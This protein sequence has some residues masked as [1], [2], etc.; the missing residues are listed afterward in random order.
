MYFDYD[1][2][3]PGEKVRNYTSLKEC[4]IKAIVCKEDYEI[5]YL[6]LR[7]K[8]RDRVFESR[9]MNVDIMLYEIKKYY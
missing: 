4:I 6:R 3:T 7:K 5:Y 9:K 1:E 8:I 2:F